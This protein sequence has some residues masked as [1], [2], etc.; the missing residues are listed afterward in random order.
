MSA[1]GV[2]PPVNTAGSW[3]FQ[4]DSRGS[5]ELPE[6]GTGALYAGLGNWKGVY[7]V[8][9][10]VK[11]KPPPLVGTEGLG[12]IKLFEAKF[13]ALCAVIIVI[14][15]AIGMV[16]TTGV[17]SPD[18]VPDTGMDSSMLSS[19]GITPGFVVVGPGSW[20]NSTGVGLAA[21]SSIPWYGCIVPTGVGCQTIRWQTL[22]YRDKLQFHLCDC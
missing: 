15:L 9:S 4:A 22:R 17:P 11:L 8:V 6:T 18:I 1:C 13:T 2:L 12:N 19:L 20:T 7:D 10:G 16:C 5:A 3:Q 21:N 14:V